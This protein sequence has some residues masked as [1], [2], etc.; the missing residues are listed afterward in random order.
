MPCAAV[1]HHPHGVWGVR[2]IRHSGHPARR[3][4][5]RQAAVPLEGA[6]GRY[7]FRELLVRTLSACHSEQSAHADPAC[8]IFPRRLGPSALTALRNIPL[9]PGTTGLA[10]RHTV[11]RPLP[12]PFPTAAKLLDRRP[13]PLTPAPAA[14]L[15][16]QRGRR[17]RSS[18]PGTQ[19]SAGP[20]RRFCSASPSTTTCR[21]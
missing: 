11:R 10:L 8:E 6:H 18:A 19:T 4:A 5:D 13:S 9:C 2:S 7:G 3:R 14:S 15:S 12:L 17:S 1:R 20:Q 21:S 16:A